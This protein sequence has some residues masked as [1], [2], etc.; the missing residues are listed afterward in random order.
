MVDKKPGAL[1]DFSAP[2]KRFLIFVAA[3]SWAIP[4]SG[5]I[6]QQKVSKPQV[7]LANYHGSRGPW[8]GARDP[9]GV[10]SHHDGQTDYLFKVGQA[11]VWEAWTDVVE[12]TTISAEFSLTCDG[13]IIVAEDAHVYGNE[14]REGWKAFGVHIPTGAPVG[15]CGIRRHVEYVGQDGQR[16]EADY[17]IIHLRIVP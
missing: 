3:I 9:D 13:Q 11:V 7:S 1:L 8:I 14:K 16:E 5:Y 6:V 4:L 15:E 10:W 2:T 12:H 17:P